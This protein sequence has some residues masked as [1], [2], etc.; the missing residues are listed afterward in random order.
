MLCY[1]KPTAALPL[2][3][4]ALFALPSRAE[5]RTVWTE[6]LTVA[7]D[8]TVSGWYDFNKAFDGE[9]DLMCWAAATSNLL[10]WWQDRNPEA[11]AAANDPEGEDIWDTFQDSFTNSG[12]NAYYG[13]QWWMS[14]SYPSLD[15]SKWSVLDGDNSG[16]YY[17][18]Y[19]TSSIK[20]SVEH[21]NMSS[22]R[23]TSLAAA[24]AD[25]VYYLGQGY[26][27]AL[28]LG[29]LEGKGGHAITLWG[30]EYDTAT[31]ELTKLYVTDSDDHVNG[32]QYVQ[33][34]LL[35]LQC[36]K[37]SGLGYDSYSLRSLNTGN[38]LWYR[39]Q[40]A[41]MD[42]AAINST[43]PMNL[44]E[45]VEPGDSVPEPATG[46]LSLLALAAL[47]ARRRRG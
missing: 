2:L 38:N 46:T 33:D 17:S 43:I 32:W 15:A 35:T 31:M 44:P 1:M 34:G 41:I 5:I 23:Y 8:G 22:Y 20:N 45:I 39:D 19:L 26:G 27:I 12:G 30:I 24:V 11:H 28:G 7:E 10:A 37:T 36:T 6:G 47:M 25:M 4:L 40:M 21:F 3:A 9:D 16:G 13:L 29:S 18:E 14:G 42:F